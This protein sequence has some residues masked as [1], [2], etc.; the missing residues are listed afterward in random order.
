M[1]HRD[2]LSGLHNRRFLNQAVFEI[3]RQMKRSGSTLSFLMF[4]L[5]HFKFF[6]DAYGH[7]A[8]DSVIA[9]FGGTLE[10]SLRRDTDY[11]F[12]YGGE[13]FSLFLTH[14]NRE[15]AISFARRFLE[16]TR[17]LGIPHVKSPHGVVMVSIGVVLAEVV[18]GLDLA[19]LIPA[20]N[21]ALY[22]A[23]DAGRDRYVLMGKDN[24]PDAKQI[25]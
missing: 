17:G 5:D 10:A 13:E 4:D 9:G 16:D 20:A 23:R 8:G 7:R 15:T 18:S 1:A 19:D 11:A 25:P 2:N 14:T 6:H 21:K 12:G 22:Q 24:S 3:L